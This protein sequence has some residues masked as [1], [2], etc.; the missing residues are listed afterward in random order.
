MGN[1]HS[2][3]CQQHAE[4]DYPLEVASQEMGLENN[5]EN[6]EE[7]QPNNDENNNM[8]ADSSSTHNSHT[9]TA[10]SLQTA[11]N[12]PRFAGANASRYCYTAYNEYHKCINECGEHSPECNSYARTYRSICPMEWIACW[13]ELRENGTWFGKY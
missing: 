8:R 5:T 1:S 2:V 9:A 12:D 4:Q 6:S 11:P 7:N 3:L 10:I 13:N